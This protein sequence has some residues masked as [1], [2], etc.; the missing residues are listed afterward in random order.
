MPWGDVTGTGSG[1]ERRSCNHSVCLFE[2]WSQEISRSGTSA[3]YRQTLTGAMIAKPLTYDE[4][5]AA[6]AAFR[7][8]PPNDDWTDSAHE[9]YVR[10]SAAIAK[11]RVTA[12]HQTNERDPEEATR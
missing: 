5:K 6:E 11:R 4:H 8:Y 2:L 1:P 7:G 10:L 3:D 12:F 9:I